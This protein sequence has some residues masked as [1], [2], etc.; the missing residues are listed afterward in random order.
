[1]E[2]QLNQ[3]KTHNDLVKH[4]DVLYAKAKERKET[5]SNIKFQYLYKK[6]ANE[7]TVK[8]AI[9]NIKSNKGSKTAGID[10]MTMEDFLKMREETVISMVIGK[11]NNYKP[12]KI[13]RKVIPKPDGGERKLGIPAIIDRIVQECIRIVIEPICEGQ[14]YEH[15]YGFRPHRSTKHALAMLQD[16][17]Y[18]INDVSW[19]VEGDISKYF[20]TI[21]HNIMIREI[22]NF[23]ITDKKVLAIIKQMLKAGIMNECEKNELGTP[24]GGILSPLLANIYLDKFDKWILKQWEQKKTQFEYSRKD[25]MMTALRKTNLK[26]AYLIRYADDWVVLTTTKENAEWWKQTISKFLKEKLNIQLNEEK[27][28]VTNFRKKYIKFLGYDLKLKS[29]NNGKRGYVGTSRP[30]IKRLENKVNEI[31]KEIRKISKENKQ[32]YLLEQVSR[33]NSMTR[34]LVNYYEG[35]TQGNPIL[36]KYEQRLYKTKTRAILPHGGKNVPANKVNNLIGV[37]SNYTQVIPTVEIDGKLIGITSLRFIN[38]KTPSSF[39]HKLTS[40]SEEGRKYYVELN[41]KKPISIRVDE[42]C[43][44]DYLEKVARGLTAPIYNFE[45]FLNRAYAFN[46][47]KGKC[48]ICG[49]KLTKANLEVHHNDNKLPINKIN[50]VSNLSC[51]CDNCHEVVHNETPDLRRFNDKQIAKIMK[52]KAKLG[53]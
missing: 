42:I 40:Y 4:L 1:M 23:G 24:Q 35:T 50:K 49:E 36:N 29:N 26:P 45:Y 27:T 2:Q 12:L 31:K 32:S 44:I 30:N 28:L 19:A 6:I 25:A 41:K 53:N 18:K 5:K 52:L 39:P 37:H 7:A 10:N 16:K 43:S 15:S 51:L 11:L 22:K 13:K 14:F 17:M 38:Y 8:T 33:V 48:K 34:G 3:I 9:H 46:R 21:D 47:D 20:D